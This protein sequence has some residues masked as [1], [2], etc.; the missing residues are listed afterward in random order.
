MEG[1]ASSR[2]S[3]SL[4]DKAIL[5]SLRAAKFSSRLTKLNEGCILGKGQFNAI[6]QRQPLIHRHTSCSTTEKR[7]KNLSQPGVGRGQCEV[8]WRF[9]HKQP[10]TLP[11]QRSLHSPTGCSATRKI[12]PIPNNHP[13]PAVKKSRQKTTSTL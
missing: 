13:K 10:N 3:S 9:P 4:C 11:D 1:N 2:T 8:P 6:Q 12:H 5:A 7:E